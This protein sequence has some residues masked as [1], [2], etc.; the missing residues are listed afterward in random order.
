MGLNKTTVAYS[1]IRS[2]SQVTWCKAFSVKSTNF[3]TY[4]LIVTGPP[5]IA[6][7]YGKWKAEITKQNNNHDSSK[8]R[9]RARS[10]LRK[11]A[12]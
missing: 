3:Q 11:Q 7:T 2:F 6:Y 10:C 12:G 9:N 8:M 1:F 4:H 5:V